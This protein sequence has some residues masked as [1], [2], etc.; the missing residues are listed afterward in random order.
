MPVHFAKFVVA[1]ASPGVI[2]IASGVSI[3]EA[4]EKLSIAW[5]SW[6]GQEVEN[7]IRWLPGG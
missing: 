4:I 2:V 1:L 5:L 7:Q 6:T 3:G